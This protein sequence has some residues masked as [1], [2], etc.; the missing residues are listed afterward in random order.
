MCARAL[1]T[2]AVGTAELAAAALV[3]AEGALEPPSQGVGGPR[4]GDAKRLLGSSQDEHAAAVHCYGTHS[5]SVASPR[6]RRAPPLRFAVE[7]GI[8]A[9]LPTRC[10]AASS[11]CWCCWCWVSR[12]A[13]TTKFLGGRTLES[14]SSVQKGGGDSGK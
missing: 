3:T 2:A 9:V 10:D 6:M 13:P 4:P 5:G 8:Q 14:S 12:L 1:V 11:T 7:V